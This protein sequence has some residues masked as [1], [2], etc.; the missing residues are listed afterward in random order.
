MPV[1]S[2]RLATGDSAPTWPAGS[3]ALEAEHPGPYSVRTGRGDG[4]KPFPGLSYIK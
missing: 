3:T 4:R 1:C 2:K